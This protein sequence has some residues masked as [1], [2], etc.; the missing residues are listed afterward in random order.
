MPKCTNCGHNYISGE[1]HCPECFEP[2]PI[3]AAIPSESGSGSN[4][5]PAS[6]ETIQSLGEQGDPF[7]G[8]FNDAP[9]KAATVQPAM[10]PPVEPAGDIRTLF[11][12]AMRRPESASEPPVSAVQPNLVQTEPDRKPIEPSLQPLS[13]TQAPPRAGFL[14]V[15][16]GQGAGTQFPLAPEATVIGRWDPTV[17]AFV[18]VDL[19]GLDT[20]AKI[21]RKHAR[22]TVRNGS[23][24]IEDLGSTNG[25][26]INRGERLIPG[27]QVPLN[28]GDE[29]IMGKTF[30]KFKLG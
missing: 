14:V 30:L 3:V 9:Q 15:A 18:E 6:P 10:K 26:Y 5:T 19:A 29:I 23:Y 16:H 24:Y 17:K 13:G 27:D 22:I 4:Q 1:L 8:L 25:T 7:A 20:E 12:P 11:N 28:D 2:V 21:S